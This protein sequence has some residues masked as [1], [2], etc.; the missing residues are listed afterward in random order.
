MVPGGLQGCGPEGKPVVLGIDP[1]R[2]LA[3]ARDPQHT[4]NPLRQGGHWQQQGLNGAQS[5]R[6]HLLLAG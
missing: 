1:E 6:S 5:Q 2:Q 3:Q 4:I